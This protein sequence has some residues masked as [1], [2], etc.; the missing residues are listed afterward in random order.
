MG[1][2]GLQ[3]ILYLFFITNEMLLI[4]KSKLLNHLKIIVS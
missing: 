2:G 4:H 1:R 3:W